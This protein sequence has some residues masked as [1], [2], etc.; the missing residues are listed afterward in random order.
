MAYSGLTPTIVLRYLNRMM[1]IS[2]Q[3]LEISDDEM[4]R[5]VFQESLPTYSKFFP[6]YF[7]ML[8]T[9]EYVLDSKRPNTYKLPNKDNL[10]IFGVHRIWLDNMN[11]FGGSMLPLVNDPYKSFLAIG[12]GISIFI[13][14][15]I[16]D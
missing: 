4:M 9:K 14:V 2:V 16:N 15:F 10:E 3:D 7:R 5:I 8:L 13:Q 12:L 6:Y 11:Q 1:G